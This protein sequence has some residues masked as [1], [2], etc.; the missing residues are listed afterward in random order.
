M[1]GASTDALFNL[2][3][4]GVKLSDLIA[5]AALCVSVYVAVTNRLSARAAAR[6]EREKEDAKKKLRV[7]IQEVSFDNDA[8]AALRWIVLNLRCGEDEIEHVL[9]SC[10]MLEPKSRISAEYEGAIIGKQ[11]VEI[12]RFPIDTIVGTG[13]SQCVITEHSLPNIGGPARIKLTSIRRDSAHTPSAV[14]ITI[15]WRSEQARRG[16]FS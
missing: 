8:P 9:E 12:V 1:A 4:Y 3:G 14:E 2:F 7:E 10:E 15:P 11:N 6:L 5:T 13:K 16:P